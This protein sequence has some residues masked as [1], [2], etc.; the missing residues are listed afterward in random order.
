MA[1]FVHGKTTVI[2]LNAVNLSAFISKSEF[3]R[4][5][6]VHETT[7]YGSSAKSKQ[8]GLIENMFSMEG[9]YDSTTTGPHDTIIPLIGTTVALIRQPEGAGT[10]KPQTLCNV[11]V[12]SYV[13]TSPV[14]DMVK[15]SC[16]CEVDGTAPE[17]DQ[18]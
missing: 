18:P 14:N 13:E 7:G 16:E 10:G 8:G 4:T 1:A 9:T 17:T 5:A 11:V 12:A 2:K 15:W 6:D 3:K